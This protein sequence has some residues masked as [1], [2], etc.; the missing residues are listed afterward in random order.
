MRRLYRNMSEKNKRLV[1]NI[2]II[3]LLISA[4]GLTW[5]N[6]FYDPP[7]VAGDADSGIARFIDA[8]FGQDPGREDTS[9]YSE[10]EEYAYTLSAVYPAS[11]V[12][13][14]Q[15]AFYY[16]DQR[17]DIETLF[18][19]T[20]VVLATA[21]DTARSGKLLNIGE[22]RSLL[23]GPS[24]LFHFSGEMPLYYFMASLSASQNAD[25]DY[26][27][28][29]LL[30]DFSEDAVQLVVKS[31]EGDIYAY[32]TDL[33]GI[34]LESFCGEKEPVEAQF[35][36]HNAYTINRVPDE[37]VVSTQPVSA[38]RLTV[39]PVLTDFAA[40]ESE[41]II[42]T[43]L[44]SF[45]FNTYTV[46]SYIESNATRVY[47]EEAGTLRITQD[48]MLVFDNGAQ[49]ELK[50]MSGMDMQVRTQNIA[51]GALI[52]EQAILP[53]LGD[54]SVFLLRQYHDELSGNYI[55]V[56]SASYNGNK[57][58][59]PGGYLARFEFRGTQLVKAYAN[60]STFLYNGITDILLPSVYAAS[61]V[62][63]KTAVT[64]LEVRYTIQNG[65]A[66]A[67][68]YYGD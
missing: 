15:D 32:D 5:L 48:G 16:Y 19:R 40:A 49:D 4:V 29:D 60:L 64:Q 11:A 14:T 21:L 8:L 1:K 30:L 24:L 46:N 51:Q 31:I 27:V 10:Y 47:V 59:L 58:N 12:L 66:K 65:S 39:S 22:W 13:N 7:Q 28:S 67:A 3:L 23:Y 17:E 57:I 36:C 52:V 20:S 38:D 33:R 63:N 61:A 43:I 9:A 6:W 41:R 54:A 37:T 2:L 26:T 53:Y 55:V 68:W 45:G 18:D 25:M 34:E 42:N 56:F 50:P 44:D 35:A 62:G